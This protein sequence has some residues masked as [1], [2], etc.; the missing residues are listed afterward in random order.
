MVIGK[1]LMLTN[2]YRTKEQAVSRL[3]EGM[4]N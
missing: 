2:K 4:S 3:Y 1:R